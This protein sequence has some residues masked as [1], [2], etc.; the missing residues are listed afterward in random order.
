MPFE[1]N[2]FFMINFLISILIYNYLK[3]H[4]VILQNDLHKNEGFE[5]CMSNNIEERFY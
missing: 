5:N 1:W 4:N 2:E 3:L